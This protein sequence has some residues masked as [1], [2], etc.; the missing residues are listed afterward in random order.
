[1]KVTPI[2]R[3]IH[4]QNQAWRVCSHEHAHEVVSLASNQTML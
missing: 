3:P 2:Y 4:P 1:M